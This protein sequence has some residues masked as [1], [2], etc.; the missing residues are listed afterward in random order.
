MKARIAGVSTVGSA[1]LLE[2]TPGAVGYPVPGVEIVLERDGARYT[3]RTGDD[4]TF[5]LRLWGA[6]PA[7][8]GLTDRAACK[9]RRSKLSSL[10]KRVAGCKK[11]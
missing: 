11:G 3:A 10:K 1:A 2:T 8:S 6:G 4:G 5:E 7:A 9:R